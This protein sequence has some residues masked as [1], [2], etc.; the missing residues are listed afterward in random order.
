MPIISSPMKL[1][2]KANSERGKIVTKSGN[3]YLDI[4][5]FVGSAKD[6]ITLARLTARWSDDLPNGGVGWC[7]YDGDD[8][9]IR[10][11][12]GNR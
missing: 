11:V 4:D 12:E 7:L 8:Q 5:I 1:Y 10:W 3:E 9:P 6:S 2:M